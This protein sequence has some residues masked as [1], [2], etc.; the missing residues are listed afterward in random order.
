[1]H[2]A[3]DHPAPHLTR[4][5][6]S[7]GYRR[8]MASAVAGSSAALLGVA[9]FISP[10]SAGLGS[11]EQLNL[12]RCGWITLMDL[13]CA[14]CGMTTAFAHAVRGSFLQSLLTQ[15]MGFVLAVATAMALLVAVYVA[16]TGSPVGRMF[17]RLWTPRVIW[18]MVLFGAASWGF[19]IA[20]YRGLLA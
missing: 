16:I 5:T 10:A 14:T 8:L 3:L 1:M 12:P 18:L 17:A 20:V 2:T 7:C 6:E 11:H 15:P 4:V 19:K 13:P 9:A